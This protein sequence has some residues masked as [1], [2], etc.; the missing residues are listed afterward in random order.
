MYLAGQNTKTLVFAVAL[1]MV[2]LPSFAQDEP[3]RGQTVSERDSKDYR[4]VG[5]RQG[6]FFVYPSVETD[7][8]FDDNIFASDTD[9]KDDAVA[10]I[11]PE[12]RVRSD[13][14]RHQIGASVRAEVARFADFTAEDYEHYTLNANGTLDITRRSDLKATVRYRDRTEERGSPDDVNGEEPTPVD[15]LRLRGEFNQ[16][17][18]R[19]SVQPKI[20]YLAFDYKDVATSNAT[21]INNDDRDRY[22]LRTG[23]R[24]SYE[25]Q[26]QY[27]AFVLFEYNNREYDDRLDDNGLIR[28]SDGYKVDAGIG[29]DLTGVTQGEVFA[30]YAEQSF[31][32]PTFED[33][34]GLDFGAQITWN[35]T[36]LTTLRG[37]AT[38]ATNET[39]TAGASS[40]NNHRFGVN[41][42][43]ELRRN[44]ILNADASYSI[45]DYQGTNR[46]DELTDVRLG[47]RYLFNRHFSV[48]AQYRMRDRDSNAVGSDYLRNQ[49]TIRIRAQM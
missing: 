34:S 2:G 29:F 17:F 18:N 23:L 39:T 24:A 43:H 41:L 40:I 11:R 15:D 20:E 8:R 42:E 44:I 14:S 9:E 26:E 31:D 48:G 3:T 19:F 38:R 6:S 7:L 49:F 30:G 35:V 45:D 36:R 4:P 32:E 10:L 25:I 13:F 12:V 37:S 27:D 47:G 33:F 1:S 46:E 22:E 5:I 16:S 28:D 21:I